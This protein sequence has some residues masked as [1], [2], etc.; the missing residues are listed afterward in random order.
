MSNDILG[1]KKRE[2]DTCFGLHG[3]SLSY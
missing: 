3:D 2:N 1:G